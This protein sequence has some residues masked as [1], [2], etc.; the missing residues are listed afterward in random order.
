MATLSATWPVWETGGAGEG[1]VTARRSHGDGAATVPQWDGW[2]W[3]WWRL[4]GGGGGGDTGGAL[5]RHRPPSR[6]GGR[7][8]GGRDCGEGGD[9]AGAGGVGAAATLP[10]EPGQ[11][12]QAPAS[13]GA[14]TTHNT[15][16]TQHTQ[17]RTHIHARTFTHAHEG[18]ESQGVHTPIHKEKVPEAPLPC[19]CDSCPPCTNLDTLVVANM[20]GLDDSAA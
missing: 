12:S 8:A 14:H 17:T 15:Q 18:C 20:E 3:C 5:S 6:E 11:T 2:W 19:R 4:G 1:A 16:H 13:H 9:T 7:G 10:C